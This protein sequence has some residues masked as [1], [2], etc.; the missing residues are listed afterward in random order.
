VRLNERGSLKKRKL[1]R[2]LRVL[3]E[4]GGSEVSWL[5]FRINIINRLE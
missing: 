1:K 2:W 4:E 3:R 5:G